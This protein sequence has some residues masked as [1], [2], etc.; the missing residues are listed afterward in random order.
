MPKLP[1]MLAACFVPSAAWAGIAELS[2]ITAE[3]SKTDGWDN[4]VMAEMLASFDANGSGA[5]NNK[6]ELEAVNC[7]SWLAIDKGVRD[8]WDGT[9]LRTIYGFD[10]N[11]IY[12]GYAL[13]VDAKLRKKADKAILACGVT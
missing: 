3:S 5:I 2:A 6:K 9:G 10:K 7:A 12:V 1:W 11:L 13:G 4:R 8:G